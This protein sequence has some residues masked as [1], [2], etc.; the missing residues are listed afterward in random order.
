MKSLVLKFTTTA[1]AV[2]AFAAVSPFVNA[3]KVTLDGFGSYTLFKKV[4]YYNKP[5]VQ[6][7]RYNSLGSDYYHNISY[8][9]DFITNRSNGRSGTLSF[10]YWAMQYYG[11]DTGIVLMTR[12]INPMA[13]GQSIKDLYRT[14]NAVYLDRKRF[15]ELNLWEYTSNGWKYRDSLSFTNKVYL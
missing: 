1:A 4:T 7:G 3:A 10:E 12:S 2:L 15:P 6:S 11:S 8:S 5:P 14:G 9:M 13:G